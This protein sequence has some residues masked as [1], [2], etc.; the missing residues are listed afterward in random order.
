MSRVRNNEEHDGPN[1]RRPPDPADKARH[2]AGECLPETC[3][4]CIEIHARRIRNCRSCRAEIIWFRTSAGRQMPIDAETVAP[5]EYELE[6]APKGGHV[7]HFATCPNANQHR[8][9]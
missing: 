9:R 1:G 3:K 7:S 4:F 5:G 8:R 6:L 2:D